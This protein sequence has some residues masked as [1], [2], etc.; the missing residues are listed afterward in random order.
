[1][2]ISVADKFNQSDVKEFWENKLLDW[3][4]GRY[5]LGNTDSAG[6]LLERI[7]DKAS[8]SLRYRLQI[9]IE[10]LGP[11]VSGKRVLELGCGSGFLAGAFMA[12]GATEYLGID[13]SERALAVAKDRYV[14]NDWDGRL[15]FKAGTIQD[16]EAANHDIVLSLGLLDWLSD[17]ELSALLDHQGT[18]DF[19]HAISEK[20]ASL[21]QLIHRAYVYISY[22]H[23]SGAYVPRYFDSSSIAELSR[24]HRCAPVYVFRASELSFGALL[25]SFP[26]GPQIDPTK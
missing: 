26:I 22:G 11:H 7:A 16:F 17:E 14:D 1:V 13:I 19:L 15:S 2:K 21:A 5:G 4:A 23:R 8:R 10:L 6:G 20:R 3:E 9:C 25:S 12:A 24:Q 18:L